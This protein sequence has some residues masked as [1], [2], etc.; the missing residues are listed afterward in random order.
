MDVLNHNA[1]TN[2]NSIKTQINHH[3]TTSSFLSYVN[4]DQNNQ[5]YVEFCEHFDTQEYQ[6]SDF[7][8]KILLRLWVLT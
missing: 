7:P 8:L 1:L 3:L 4:F 5:P 6:M 2:L